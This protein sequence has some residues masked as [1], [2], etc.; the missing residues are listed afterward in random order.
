MTR[1]AWAGEKPLN[2]VPGALPLAPSRRGRRKAARLGQ[3][4]FG[5]FTGGYLPAGVR[6]LGYCVFPWLFV[7]LSAAGLLL[8]AAPAPR[9][10]KPAARVH[11]FP[12]SLAGRGV[13][14][15]LAHWGV[16]GI[17]LWAH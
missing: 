3:N 4:L 10:L 5:R 15:T 11:S 17:R 7:A 2:Q 13:A 16:L 8:A 6:T 9:S 12:V 1:T 14:A